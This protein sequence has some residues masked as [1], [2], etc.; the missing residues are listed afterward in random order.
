MKADYNTI[1]AIKEY[2]NSMQGNEMLNDYLTPLILDEKMNSVVSSNN[3]EY[4]WLAKIE[5]GDVEL[6][7]DFE[8]FLEN[9]TRE[10]LKVVENVLTSFEGSSIINLEEKQK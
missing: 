6:V 1:N 8:E 4:L 10:L 3:L 5:D 9:Y 2:V 7:C